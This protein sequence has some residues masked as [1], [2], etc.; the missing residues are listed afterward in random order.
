MIGVLF[1]AAALFWSVF[2]QAGSTLNLFADRNT[3]NTLFGWRF[4][5]SWFQ[6]LNSLFLIIFAPVFAWVWVRLAA[7]GNEPSSADEVRA[8]AWCSS[9]LGF[10]ILIGAG[11]SAERARWPARCG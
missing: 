8:G 3:D 1:L 2:E 10:A 4:P 11:A 9:A 6:S 5:S 7:S